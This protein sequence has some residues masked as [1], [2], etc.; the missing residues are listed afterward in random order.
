LHA[1]PKLSVPTLFDHGV[2][3]F[4]SA[5]KAEL[6]ARHFERAHH[7]N[8]NSVTA[9]RAHTVNRTVNKYF[10]RSHPHVTKL[11]SQTH[12]NSNIN[13]ISQN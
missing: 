1:L 12:M 9:N 2:Q 11:G 8:L 4:I 5:D 3:V 10:Y 7:L 6:L 13:S